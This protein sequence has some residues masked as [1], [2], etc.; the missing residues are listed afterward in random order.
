MSR[1][2]SEERR[3]T[4]KNLECR[5]KVWNASKRTHPLSFREGCRGDR[6][7]IAHGSSFFGTGSRQPILFVKSLPGSISGS[8]RESCELRKLTLNG[9]TLTLVLIP[10]ARLTPRSEEH[11]SEL[12]SPVHLVCRLLLEKKKD[13]IFL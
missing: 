11:T 5:Q 12:Q 4:A 10:G 6:R 9:S 7:G 3:L 2:D 13:N 1:G 8:I